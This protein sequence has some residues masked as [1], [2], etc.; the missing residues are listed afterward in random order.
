M[1]GY[2]QIPQ[3]RGAATS[4]RVVREPNSR[5]PTP[6]GDAAEDRS[7]SGGDRSGRPVKSLSTVIRDL[8]ERCLHFVN[9]LSAASFDVC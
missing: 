2:C 8:M 4:V 1:I 3:D 5:L 6:K 9:I 7:P